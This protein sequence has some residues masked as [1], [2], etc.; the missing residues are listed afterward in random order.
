MRSIVV[1]LSAVA[2][3]TACASQVPSEPTGVVGGGSGTTLS[4]PSTGV[5]KNWV[6]HLVGSNEVPSRD[7]PAQGEVKFQLNADGTELSYR[8]ISSNI[9]NVIA[10][11]IHLAPAGTNG[12]IVVFLFGTVAAGG[13]AQDGVLATGTI[14]AANLINALAGQPLSALIDRMDSG[15]AYVNVHTNDG[16]GSTNTGAG[17]FPGGEIRGQ[18]QPAGH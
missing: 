17:D 5:V 6:A 11:H 18:I 12:N 3:A 15:G 8:L 2:F 13:G 1:L 10:S 7:T 4:K 16:V 14:T 9:D